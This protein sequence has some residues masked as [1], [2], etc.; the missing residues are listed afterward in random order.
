M[1]RVAFCG[2]IHD[3]DRF[4]L[5]HTNQPHFILKFFPQKAEFSQ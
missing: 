5:F 1:G 3:P 4:L 2:L